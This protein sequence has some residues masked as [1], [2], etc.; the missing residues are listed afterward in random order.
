MSEQINPPHVVF[1][2]HNRSTNDV[3]EIK[4]IF[5]AS[6]SKSTVVT[7]CDDMTIVDFRSGLIYTIRGHD[8]DI[9]SYRNI[10]VP[11]FGVPLTQMDVLEDGT[12]S[13]VS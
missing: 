3:K 11:P 7:N 4:N 13:Y 8:C 2:F 6:S 5:E 9:K 1:I 12:A 10:E